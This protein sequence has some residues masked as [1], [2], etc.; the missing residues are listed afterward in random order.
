MPNLELVD[1]SMFDEIH[2]NLLTLLDRPRPKEEWRRIFEYSWSSPEEHV[3]YALYEDGEPV[4]FLG[5]LF[6]ER[7]LGGAT[8]RFCNVSSW[9][10]REPY[11]H[12]ATLLVLA[13]RRLDGYTITNLSP[14]RIAYEVFERLGFQDL[15]THW[16][17]LGP[18]RILRPSTFTSEVRLSGSRDHLD[19]VLG[20]SCSRILNDHRDS[21]YHA[22]AEF[23]GGYCYVV[24]TLARRWYLP[25]VR[26]HFFS[27][28][29]GFERT[30]PRLQFYWLR[31]HG[32]V[33]AECDSRLLEGVELP[34]SRRIPRTIP[35]MYRS[36]D[37]ER[38]QIDNL[39]S[40][41][42]LLNLV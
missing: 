35:R 32:A 20:D 14:N 42:V 6:H 22:A 5:L 34:G 12:Q 9:I 7:E 17:I 38:S 13:L 29:E 39:Y 11:R 33:V 31:R 40:E 25:S 36:S 28:K 2:R 24:Y 18:G 3:G 1:P 23:P 4:A 26:I 41:V 16:T 19:D 21:T 37:L 30:L 27:D 15:E 8:R 10:A